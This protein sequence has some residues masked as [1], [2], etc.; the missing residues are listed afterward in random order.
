MSP[1]ILFCHHKT[2]AATQPDALALGDGGT[3]AVTAKATAGLISR[4]LL[5]Y[6]ITSARA[7][8]RG[9]FANQS[10]LSRMLCSKEKVQ[11]CASHLVHSTRPPGCPTEPSQENQVGSRTTRDLKGQPVLMP[12]Q[13]SQP[14]SER[15]Q[16]AREFG[17]GPSCPWL[18]LLLPA[19]TAPKHLPPAADW[20]NQCPT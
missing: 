19:K 7:S 20:Q 12:P 1:F 17:D 8:S 6:L 10:C 5:L 13:T 11:T 14:A 4:V 18:R 2:Q 15:Y 9:H 16:E 3:P